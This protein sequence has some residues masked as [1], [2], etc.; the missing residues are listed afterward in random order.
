MI[1]AVTLL[2]IASFPLSRVRE[3]VGVR[4]RVVRDLT[5]EQK[6]PSPGLRPASPANGRGES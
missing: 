6:L 1:D 5:A 2:R 3:R 4:A